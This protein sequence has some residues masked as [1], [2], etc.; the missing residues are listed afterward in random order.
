MIN[1]EIR[2]SQV[3]LSQTPKPHNADSPGKR[4]NGSKNTSTRENDQ[5]TK[6]SSLYSIKSGLNTIAK[7]IRAADKTIKAIANYIERMKAGLGRIIKNYPPFSP[8]SEERAKLL[9]SYISLRKQIDQLT[10]PP[11]KN[12]FSI[13]IIIDSEVVPENGIWDILTDFNGAHIPGLS[14]DAT[15]EDIA[16][17]IEKLKTAK[18]KILQIGEELARETKRTSSQEKNAPFS[19]LFSGYGDELAEPEAKSLEMGKWL[20]GE[21]R[22]TLSPARSE[23]L[24]LLEQTA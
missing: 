12:E 18:E 3:L 24:S 17:S 23:L 16:I 4:S 1:S 9:K 10:I 20:S 7:N 2:I 15:D 14:E 6:I 5:L 8:G 13:E 11:P 21:S 19:K 22:I